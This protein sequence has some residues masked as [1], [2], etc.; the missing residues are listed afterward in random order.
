MKITVVL[1][2]SLE[3]P[4]QIS[5]KGT[6]VAPFV[7]SDIVVVE[8]TDVV[9]VVESDIVVVVKND[10]V[11][12]QLNFV[13]FV[14]TAVVSDGGLDIVVETGDVILV[15]VVIIVVVNS[16]QVA[17]FGRLEQNRPDSEINNDMPAEFA[18]FL[19]V[20]LT[21]AGERYYFRKLKNSIK[22]TIAHKRVL[23][24]K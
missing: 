16:G 21:E 6:E 7:E 13:V 5:G 18:G 9:S 19:H 10:V 22:I 8:K 11:L 1:V 17:E 15:E 20:K 12:V 4:N 3:I 24:D 2:V 23:Q 14:K